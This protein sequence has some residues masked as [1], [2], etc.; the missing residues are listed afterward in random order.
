MTRT[1]ITGNR[2]LGLLIFGFLCSIGGCTEEG[3][4]APWQPVFWG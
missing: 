4:T 1:R 3:D 2:V